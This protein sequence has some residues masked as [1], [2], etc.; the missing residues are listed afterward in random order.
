MV[1]LG[2][3]GEKWEDSG[4]TRELELLKLTRK[5]STSPALALGGMVVEFAKVGNTTG[6]QVWGKRFVWGQTEFKIL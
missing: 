1:V 3:G 4:D 2:P 6:H 5:P